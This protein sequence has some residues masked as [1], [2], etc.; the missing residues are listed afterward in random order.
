MRYLTFEVRAMQ[1]PQIEGV[2][3][4]RLLVNYRADPEV[5]GA[6]LPAPFR[7]QIVNGHAVA[8]ICLLRMAELRPRPLPRWVG[9]RSENAAH[10][11]AIE[12]DDDGGTHSGVYIPRRDS[13]SLVNVIV[14]GRA[15]P[16]VHHRARF[17]VH[18]TDQEISIRLSSLDGSTRVDV[19]A[20]VAD[21][22]SGGDL[23]TDLAEASNFFEQGSVGYSATHDPKRFD[24]LVLQTDS[25][26][27][28]PVTIVEAHSTFFEDAAVFPA[29]S[30]V[31]D[32]A[33]LMRRV[34]VKWSARPSLRAA[35]SSGLSR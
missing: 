34:P 19:K 3:D 11:I 9:L 7:P 22:Y 26:S 30:A 17:D 21:E 2:I 6:L 27:V 13:A 28:T 8:G 1:R 16:G 18:E 5:V 29:G 31:L 23:F 33:L 32:N 20:E 15:Y 14:G 12:W 4:R 10:R 35:T 24:G 25:W